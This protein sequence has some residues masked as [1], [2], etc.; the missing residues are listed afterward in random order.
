MK[1]AAYLSAKEVADQMHCTR[2]TVHRW[3]N[4]GKLR[5]IKPGKSLLIAP[6][7]LRDFINASKVK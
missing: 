6:Q 2:R 3:I 5:A 4:A 7:D 1:H